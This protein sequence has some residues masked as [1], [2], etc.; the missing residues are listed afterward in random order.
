M[1]NW[2]AVAAKKIPIKESLHF[3]LRAEFFNVLNTVN[4]S[5]PTTDLQNLSFGKI[6]SAAAGR[7]GQVSLTLS[8]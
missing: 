3:L 8:W 5:S 7:S 2:N 6:T 4:F 1:I